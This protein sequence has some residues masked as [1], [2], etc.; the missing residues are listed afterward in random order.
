MVWSNITM[1]PHFP[2]VAQAIAQLYPQSGGSPIDGVF[3]LDTKSIAALMR[4][5][6]PI[7]VP[8]TSVVLTADT[9][10]AFLLRAQYSV[11]D[12]DARKDLLQTIAKT[13]VDRLLGSTLPPPADMAAV[14]AP[15]AA[16]RR[17]MA[18]SANAD[19]E[20]LFAD[21]KMD[22]SFVR[23]GEADGIAV[24][25]DNAAANKLEAYLDMKVAYDT[26]DSPGG[27]RGGRVTVTL[28][29][30]VPSTSLPNY[31]VGN[32]LDLPKGTER[33][34]VSV[35]TAVPMVAAQL[36]GQQVGMQTGQVFGWFANS[37]FFDIPPGGTRT[38]VLETKGVVDPA[39]PLKVITQP[40]AIVRALELTQ[41]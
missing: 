9:A 27:V 13:T 24:T 32:A 31:V 41:R 33:L 39:L 28:T 21:V 4:F 25:V 2:D 6:G 3:L 14:F 36:D 8:D 40:L 5:T 23:S 37:K 12:I 20:Q 30:N 38:L 10:E 17:L 29:N 16:E 35:Y 1:A 34:W 22:G 15:L 11:T 19:E 7:E 26:V 18:W